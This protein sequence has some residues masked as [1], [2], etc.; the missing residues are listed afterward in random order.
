MNDNVEIYSNLEY[1][2]VVKKTGI[3]T[4]IKKIRGHDEFNLYIKFP[5]IKSE[6]IEDFLDV[7]LDSLFQNTYDF[8][9]DVEKVLNRKKAIEEQQGEIS[10]MDHYL[11][12]K[13][14]SNSKINIHLNN[15]INVRTDENIGRMMASFCIMSEM[16][17]I[18]GE[19]YDL[20]YSRDIIFNL[21]EE[22]LKKYK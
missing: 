5:I 4:L 13:I 18:R 9:Q 6:S 3:E 17:S 19:L 22:K 1:I 11:Y 12:N 8:P 15:V 2:D 20:K 14:N 21:L 16:D 7:F 10:E